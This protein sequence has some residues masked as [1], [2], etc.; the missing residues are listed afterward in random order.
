MAASSG[1]SDAH[2]V[3]PTR[4]ELLCF[5][6]Q[7]A[8]VMAVDHIVKICSDFY[9]HEEIA[10]A[11]HLVEQVT[12]KRLKKRQGNEAARNTLEDIMKLILDPEINL[13]LYYVVDFGRLPPVDIEHC[14]V[15]AILRELQSL[16]AEVRSI[17]QLKSEV[18]SLK[19]ELS[20]LRQEK[21]VA[22]NSVGEWPRLSAQSAELHSPSLAEMAKQ[23]AADPAAFKADVKRKRRPVK[24]IIGSSAENCRLK[25]VQ[26]TRQVDIFISRLHPCTTAAELSDCVYEMKD[27]I[28]VLEVNCHQLKSKFESLYSS[29]HVEIAVDSAELKRA[30]DVFMASDHWPQGV[31]VKRFFK[32]RNGAQEQ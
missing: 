14:D 21:A 12:S 25:S 22:V 2:D 30:I 20:K 9:R 17:I 4:N 5:M 6:Q 29:F 10:T 15:S 16:R 13:P 27:N 32:T 8:N 7:K 31:F 18:D 23:A 28:N 19:E 3:Q 1:T 11:R 24:A 26:T